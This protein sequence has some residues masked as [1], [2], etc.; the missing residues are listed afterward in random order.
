MLSGTRDARD[1]SI[2][3]DGSLHNML[4]FWKD[5][6]YAFRTLTK[7]PGFAIIGIVT[8]ALGMAVNTTLF[9]VVNGFLLRPLP[10]PR[11]EQI[12]VLSLKQSSLPGSYRFSYPDYED[13][14]DQAD[15]F[16][17]ILAYRVTLS[18]VD[19]DQKADHCIISRVSS[20]YFSSLGIKPA[21]GRFILPTEGRA[22]GA[23]PVMVLGYSYWRKR[24]G[25]DPN[26]AGKKVEVNGNPFTVVGVAPPDFHGTY[27]V[28]DMDAYIPF[29]AEP[30]ED[31]DNPIQK[32]WSSRSSRTLTVMGRLKPGVTM[33]QAT[34]TLDVISQRIAQEHPDTEKG[35]TVRLY[36]EKLA[37]PEPDPQN[38]IPLAAIAFMS[39]AGLV[40]L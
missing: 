27:S 35:F 4:S 16:S 25:S 2:I 8:L 13:L 36:P 32:I 23:D 5:I 18:G 34:A 9:S 39:M 38:P 37:R 31:P 17:D 28:L 10:V 6:Q 19:V 40:L 21:Y 33:K 24:F 26:V 12:T 29:S 14:R 30:N 7:N 3:S 20:N 15:S 11:P 1:I 22:P